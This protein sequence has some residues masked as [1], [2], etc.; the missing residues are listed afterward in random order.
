MPSVQEGRG[1]HEYPRSSAPVVGVHFILRPPTDGGVSGEGPGD[2]QSLERPAA[3]GGDGIGDAVPQGTDHDRGARRTSLPLLAPRS[4]ADPRRR[5][6]EFG[7][8]LCAVAAWLQVPDGGDRLVQPVSRPRGEARRPIPASRVVS[9]A[10][11][12]IL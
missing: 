6:L 9:F 5:A 7:Y 1:V 3:H 2:G 10:G 12:N 4:G 8:H 11:L